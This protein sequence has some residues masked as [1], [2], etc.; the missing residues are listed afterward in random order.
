MIANINYAFN[1]IETALVSFVS[2]I[3]AKLQNCMI[4]LPVYVQSTGDFSYVT[5]QQFI[6][7]DNE[8]VIHKLPRVVLKLDDIQLNTA[9]DTNM[10]N[11]FVYHFQNKNYVC[12]ARRKASNINLTLY[13]VSSN[14]I[15]ML[16]HFEVLMACIG[17]KD[18]VFTYNFL[19][20]TFQSAYVLNGTSQEY[21]SIDMG[22]GGTRDCVV[23][24]NIELQIHL[25]VPDVM[26]IQE[27][28][29][30]KFTRVV[31]GI[32]AENDLVNTLYNVVG[33]TSIEVPDLV[34]TEKSDSN[35]IKTEEESNLHN[36]EN[37]QVDDGFNSPY[38]K[39]RASIKE[40]HNFPK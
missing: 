31:Y 1:Q 25:L 9:E 14:Y 16:N 32:R 27:L 12:N 18:N 28:D 34:P 40:R 7:T 15:T 39:V 23:Q 20:N 3:Q 11:T 37:Q 29:E 35:Q 38:V 19:G 33:P 2:D 6:Q 13:F 10:Y 22:Q 5:N 26:T 30:N 17:V 21:P 8:A 36:P 24:M 4:D